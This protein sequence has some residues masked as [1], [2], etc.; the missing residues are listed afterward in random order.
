MCDIC[1]EHKEETKCELCNCSLCVY[2]KC[3]FETKVGTYY[4]DIKVPFCKECLSKIKI[5]KSKKGKDLLERFGNEI[6][7]I[8]IENIITEKIKIKKKNKR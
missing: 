6:K 2:C 5:G 3:H 1:K 4:M 8:L 7:E